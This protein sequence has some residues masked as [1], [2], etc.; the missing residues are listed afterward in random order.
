MLHLSINF[1]FFSKICLKLDNRLDTVI[2][3]RYKM[4]RGGQWT[5]P[6]KNKCIL[7]KCI[8]NMQVLFYISHYIYNNTQN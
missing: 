4:H 2:I 3:L 8:L 6:N 1:V 5:V 7:S